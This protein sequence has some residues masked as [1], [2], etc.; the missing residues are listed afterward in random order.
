MD[1]C[2]PMGLSV[3]CAHFEW[4]SCFL[5][6]AVQYRMGVAYTM[7]YLDN[8]LFAGPQDSSTC[9][10]LLQAFTDLCQELGVSL[11]HETFTKVFD[12][13]RHKTQLHSTAELATSGQVGQGDN[14]TE[15]RNQGS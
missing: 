12:F 7:H 2:M 9:D 5:E 1:K 10:C 4:F 15:G 11:A 13:P 3:S 8:F 6:W 14:F